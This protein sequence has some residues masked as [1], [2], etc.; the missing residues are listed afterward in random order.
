[1]HLHKPR[2]LLGIFEMKRNRLKHI[3]AKI[4]PIVSFSED[5][6]AKGASVESALVGIADLEDQLHKV[7]V[8]NFTRCARPTSAKIGCKCLST[9]SAIFHR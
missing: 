8:S 2:A 7:S 3:C 4:F 9:A 5:C 6:V 1:M